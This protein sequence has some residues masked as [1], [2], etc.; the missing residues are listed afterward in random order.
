MAQ[1]MQMKNFDEQ[2]SM[3]YNEIDEINKRYDLLKQSRS[4]SGSSQLNVSKNDSNFEQDLNNN[5]IQ[6]G[7]AKAIE[8]SAD[9]KSD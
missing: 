4:Y 5:S 1:N 6:I 8:A 3:I 7:D 9:I 2:E